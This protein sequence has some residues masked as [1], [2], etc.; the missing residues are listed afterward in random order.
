[1]FN[2]ETECLLDY[3]K[4]DVKQNIDKNQKSSD[5]SITRREKLL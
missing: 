3:Q 2:V 1:M 5:W 4:D